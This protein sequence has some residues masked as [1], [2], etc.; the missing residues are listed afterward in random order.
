MIYFKYYKM[1]VFIKISV[2]L[3]SVH[4]FNLYIKKNL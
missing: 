1:H 3:T 4:V 2:M